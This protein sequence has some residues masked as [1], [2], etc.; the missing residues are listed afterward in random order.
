MENCKKCNAVK[1]I[2]YKEYC[3]KCDIQEIIKGKNNSYSIF[4]IM[5]YG[6]DFIEDFDRGIVWG[7]ICDQLY[8]NDTY[9]DYHLDDEDE[10]DLMLKKVLDELKIPYENN[11]IFLWVSW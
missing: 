3:P 7:S 1:R 10:G 6:E 11:Q 8:S 2:Y 5:Y 9:I 4:P